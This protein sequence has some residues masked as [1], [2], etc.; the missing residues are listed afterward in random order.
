MINSDNHLLVIDPRIGERIKINKNKWLPMKVFMFF[1]RERGNAIDYQIP[2]TG[3]LKDP[4]FNVWDV[5]L[6]IVTNIFIKPPTT[7]YH[8]EVTTVENNVEKTLSCNWMLRSAKLVDDEEKFVKKVV[9]FLKK[10]P[11][12]HI[13]VKPFVYREKEREY[14]AFFEA[15]KKYYLSNRNLQA[16]SEADSV[17][18]EKMSVK[19][20]AFVKYVKSKVPDKMMFTMQER[21][22]ALVGT[23]SITARYQTLLKDREE[24]FRKYFKEEGVDQRTEIQEAESLVPFNGFSYYRISYK[25]DLPSETK[26]A[27]EKLKELDSKQPRRPYTDERKKTRRFFGTEK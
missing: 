27:Y 17:N 21:C 12:A 10:N 18:V 3:N 2:I 5:L 15:K 20:S 19:D 22:A 16:L 9:E 4:K 24:V 25:G 13:L 23:K 11:G 26:E 8:Y 6:D 1:V 7:P 14:I